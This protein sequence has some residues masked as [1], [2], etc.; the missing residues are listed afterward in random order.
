MTCFR[1]TTVPLGDRPSN[2][3]RQLAQLPWFVR[4]VVFK[5]LIKAGLRPVALRLGHDPDQEWPF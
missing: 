1:R 5:V 2:I 3:G 4:N